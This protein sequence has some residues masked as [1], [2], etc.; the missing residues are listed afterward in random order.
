MKATPADLAAICAE[1]PEVEFEQSS[2][3]AWKVPAGPRAKTFLNYREPRKDAIDPA[4][5]ERYEDLLVVHVPDE[6]AK[7]ALVGDPGLPF[8]A[9]EHFN[10]YNAVLIQESR[11]RE[12]DRDF[13]V[14][15]ITE[16]WACRA[17]KRLAK[18]YFS[19]R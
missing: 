9:T 13:L 14:E 11:I 10:G 2:Y 19:T 6:N 18:E 7:A 12:L 5:G 17:P 3:P 4:T 16:A 15:V 1:L 8:F